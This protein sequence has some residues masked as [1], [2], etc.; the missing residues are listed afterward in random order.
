[1]FWRALSFDLYNE[2]PKDKL[3]FLTNQIAKIL[4]PLDQR[5]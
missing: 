1:V 4:C 2:G 5:L 3:L